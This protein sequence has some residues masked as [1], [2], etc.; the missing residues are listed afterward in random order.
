VVDILR[1]EVELAVMVQQWTTMTDNAVFAVTF[2]VMCSFVLPDVVS[3][4]TKA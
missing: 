2:A 1:R 4:V 3:R